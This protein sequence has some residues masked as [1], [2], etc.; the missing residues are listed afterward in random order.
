MY[1]GDLLT[2]FFCNI[3]WTISPVTLQRL[4]GSQGPRVVDDVA[5]ATIQR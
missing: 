5:E 3:V 2:G 1:A 4:I